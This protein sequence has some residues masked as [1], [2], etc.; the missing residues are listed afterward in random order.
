M[1]P[2][3]E[4]KASRMDIGQVALTCS[5]DIQHGQVTWSEGWT[6]GLTKVVILCNQEIPIT[7]KSDSC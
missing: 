5:A 6:E 2:G 7:L 4:A 3:H 1:E